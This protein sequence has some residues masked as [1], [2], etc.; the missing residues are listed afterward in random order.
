MR[1]LALK[2]SDDLTLTLGAA[3]GV[4]ITPGDGL[5]LAEEIARKS[6]RR[7]LTE[8]AARFPDSFVHVGSGA[9]KARA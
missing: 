7:A 6:M 8:E 3:P 5:K 4:T 1:R 9:A 2:I